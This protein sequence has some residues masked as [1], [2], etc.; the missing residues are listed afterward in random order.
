MSE[1]LVCTFLLRFKPWSSRSVRVGAVVVDVR[2][3]RGGVRTRQS[4]ADS[5]MC[6]GITPALVEKV[7]KKELSTLPR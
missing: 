7:D 4:A 1:I 6:N 5:T 2:E 3:G